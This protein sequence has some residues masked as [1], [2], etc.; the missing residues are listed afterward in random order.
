GGWDLADTL[1]LL[2]DYEGLRKL[3]NKVVNG[4]SY[5]LLP[6]FRG[7][8]SPLSVYVEEFLHQNETPIATGVINDGGEDLIAIRNLAQAYDVAV[9]I[10]RGGLK[11]GAIADLWGMPTRTLDIAAHNRKTARGKWVSSIVP[12]DFAGKD[13]LLFDKDAVSGAT[14]QQAVK[15]VS[16]FKPASIAVYFAHNFRHPGSTFGTHIEGLPPRLRVYTPKT[17]PMHRA[18]DAYIEAHERLQTMYGRRR[19]IEHAFEDQSTILKNGYPEFAEVL[20]SFVERH[21]DTFD[22][23]NP[24]LAGVAKL[25]ELILRKLEKVYQQNAGLLRDNLLHDIPGMAQNFINIWRT[26]EALPPDYEEDLVRAR[27]ERRVR[28]CAEKRGVENIHLPMR[29]LAALHAAREAVKAGFEVA[30]IVGPEGFAYEP[31]FLDQGV[32]TVAL[33]IPESAPGVTREITGSEDL[34][35][36]QGKRVLVVEDDVRTGATLKKIIE[37]LS[38]N[39]TCASLG[40]YLGQPAEY[41]E[42]SNIPAEFKELYVANADR[43]TARKTFME[44]ME[45]KGLRLFKNN[46]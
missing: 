18:G 27:Y 43:E 36:L 10:A 41:Q 30:L 25:R 37:H 45:S 13:V 5:S 3:L 28:L 34:A 11:Q 23:L 19:L 4:E 46:I 31:Y 1:V 35:V 16:K 15:M 38:A 14:M 39:V 44:Y 12:E 40:L 2:E 20:V 29:P 6:S 8:M 24:F 33:N 21:L 32:Q 17:A 42:M 22:N 7:L 9:P 26:T